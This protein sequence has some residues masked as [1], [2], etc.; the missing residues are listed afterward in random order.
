[1]LSRVSN[2]ALAKT[3]A[4]GAFIC[5]S[6][7]F[8]H[9]LTMQRRVRS[10]GVYQESMQLLR[11]HAP[12]NSLL[13]KPIRAGWMQ[14]GDTQANIWTAAQVQLQIPLRGGLQKGVLYVRASRQVPEG[15]EQLN[16]TKYQIDRLELSLEKERNRKLVVFKGESKE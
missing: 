11:E 1:M 4:F 3:A 5:V 10:S 6:M 12:A 14:L 15:A 7:G 9:Q 8:V 16:D 13:G 2:Q